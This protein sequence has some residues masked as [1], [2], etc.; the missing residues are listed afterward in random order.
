MEAEEGKMNEGT[1]L[2]TS[3]TSTTPLLDTS[4]VRTCGPYTCGSCGVAMHMTV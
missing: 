1:T 4:L 2:D 3:A